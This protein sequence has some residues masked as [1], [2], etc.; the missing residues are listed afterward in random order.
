MDPATNHDKLET[1]RQI[2]DLP[3]LPSALSSTQC[4][5][6][7]SRGRNLDP[8]GSNKFSKDKVIKVNQLLFNLSS[9][10]ENAAVCHRGCLAQAPSVLGVG[11]VA[12]LRLTLRWSKELLSFLIFS[13]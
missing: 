9:K 5:W 11:I 8:P 1:F 7:H 10:E 12:P 3:S 13:V 4:N 2:M 6:D